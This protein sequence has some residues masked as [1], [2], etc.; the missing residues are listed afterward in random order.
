[1]VG[2]V[3]TG[4]L[5]RRRVVSNISFVP[6]AAQVEATK[7]TP[8]KP[9]TKLDAEDKEIVHTLLTLAKLARDVKGV[10]SVVVSGATGMQLVTSSTLCE[11]P[12]FVPTDTIDDDMDDGMGVPLADVKRTAELMAAQVDNASEGDLAPSD[13][14]TKIFTSNPSGSVLDQLN[15]RKDHTRITTQQDQNLLSRVQSGFTKAAAAVAEPLASTVSTA[16]KAASQAS[17]RAA[18][19]T[20]AAVKG[21]SSRGGAAGADGAKA[22]GGAPSR[23]SLVQG[24]GDPKTDWLL[25]E[26]NNE[27]VRYF[28]LSGPE[29]L[30]KQQRLSSTDLT[31]FE[32]YAL[33][34]KIN[35]RI[36]AEASALYA[37]FIP[38]VMDYLEE[39][40]YGRV[41]MTGAGIGGSLATVLALMM[42]N[43]GLRRDHLLPVYAFNAP[44]VLGQVPDYKL[45]CSKDSCTDDMD[46]IV[47]EV[48]SRGVLAELGL[49]QDTVRNVLVPATTLA[50]RLGATSNNVVAGPGWSDRLPAWFTSAGADKA[51]TTASSAAPTPAMVGAQIETGGGR[52]PR[53]LQIFSPIGQVMMYEG[54]DATPAHA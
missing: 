51:K 2:K 4:G 11:T 22:D 50:V 49:G 28:I 19:A 12:I 41:C 24:A 36:Y 34:V 16:A 45:W 38:L 1:M 30:E 25:V 33:G 47:A 13:N 8:T 26:D 9:L 14:K 20:I 29:E 17:T 23:A 5:P 37:R 10:N 53:N 31:A 42:V 54:E 46:E 43:R 6:A 44:V 21:A 15:A 40:P 7:V 39:N 48:M 52:D 27:Q 32:S 35:R 18:S 3:K